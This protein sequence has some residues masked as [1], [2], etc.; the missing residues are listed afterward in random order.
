MIKIDGL[1]QYSSV[2]S[3]TILLER[4]FCPTFPGS[5]FRIDG[6]I[7]LH[8]PNRLLKIKSTLYMYH[9]IAGTAGREDDVGHV[10]CLIILARVLGNVGLTLLNPTR[11][12][13]SR[14]RSLLT[15]ECLPV[16][17]IGLPCR[18]PLNAFC[19]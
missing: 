8:T 19:K 12:P 15:G 10:L 18:D 4:L 16:M 6:H 5:P 9:N 1:S 3:F 14:S 11:K 7:Y 13:R 2:H 17:V